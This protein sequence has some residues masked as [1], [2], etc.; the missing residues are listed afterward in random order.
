[1]KKR[2][3]VCCLYHYKDR[4]KPGSNLHYCKSPSLERD[5]ITGEKTTRSCFLIRTDLASCGPRGKYY[6]PST[7]STTTSTTT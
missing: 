5:L 4:Q 2:F 1:M 6:K 3:C 7:T